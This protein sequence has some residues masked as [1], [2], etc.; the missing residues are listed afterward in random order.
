MSPKGPKSIRER[1]KLEFNRL[2]PAGG[3]RQQTAANKVRQTSDLQLQVHHYDDS[4]TG[5]K[6]KQAGV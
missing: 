1:S 4:K 2:G 6:S 3:T 5:G